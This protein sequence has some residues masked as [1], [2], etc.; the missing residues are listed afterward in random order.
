MRGHF[1]GVTVP[2]SGM[3]LAHDPCK[4]T[5]CRFYTTGFVRTKQMTYSML[6]ADDITY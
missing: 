1:L 2:L 6:F 5:T 3:C 4:S